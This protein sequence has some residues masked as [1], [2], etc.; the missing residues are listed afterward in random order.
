MM[1]YKHLFETVATL[2]AL[3]LVSAC[4]GGSSSGG[5]G[6]NPNTPRAAS[7]QLNAVAGPSCLSPSSES[8]YFAP[9]GYE[10]ITCRWLCAKD[11]TYNYENVTAVFNNN[12]PSKKWALVEIT[13][14][15][16]MCNRL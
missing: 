11:S 6:S 12:R 10:E 15:A 16:G 1:N 9:E 14:S 4:G 3:S 8:T 13:R 5:A 2:L 7:Y